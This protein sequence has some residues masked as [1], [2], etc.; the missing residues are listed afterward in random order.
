M[1]DSSGD[2]FTGVP[3]ML[4]RRHILFATPAL[5]M[6][7]TLQAA[8]PIDLGDASALRSKA[9]SFLAALSP[10]HAAEARFPFG[11]DVQKRWNF[12]GVGGFIKP[13]LRLEQMDSALKDKA[14]DMLTAVLSER[15]ISKARDVMILQQVLRD[16][17]NSPDARHP[18]RFSFAFFGTP[19]ATES[20]AMRLEGHHLSLTFN[21]ANDRLTGIT[22]SSFSVNP[23]RVTGG[24]SD[25][26]ITLKREDDLARTLAR[27]LT[28]SKSTRA[29]FRDTP[30]RN[31]QATAGRE[32]P[33]GAYEGIAAADLAGPQRSLLAELIDAYTAEHLSAAFARAVTSRLK[34]E[35]DASAHFAFAGAREIGEPA[36]YRIHSKH[37]L[38][39]FA[40][41]DAAAQHLHTIFHLT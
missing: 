12:M 14:W 2:L 34:S 17:G 23:N 21:I 4:N 32:S 8:E 37:M 38:I 28:G 9:E 30:F 7:V 5:L 33:F 24:S 26:L 36:Y 20:W 16:Q 31:I 3:A 22:P 27:D 11:G 40:A 18:E 29:F 19:S 13:G 1:P 15:G 35:T 41:V 25:G 39:E 6:P 10:E